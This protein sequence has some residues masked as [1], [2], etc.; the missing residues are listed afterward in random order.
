ML[1]TWP[2]WTFYLRI[3]EVKNPQFHSLYF[4]ISTFLE[5]ECKLEKEKKNSVKCLQSLAVTAGEDSFAEAPAEFADEAAETSHWPTRLRL[6][7]TERP[8]S[9]WKKSSK[10]GGIDLRNSCT[11]L[12]LLSRPPLPLPQ[13]RYLK[14]I[15]KSGYQALPWVRYITQNGGK[16]TTRRMLVH[17]APMRSYWATVGQFSAIWWERALFWCSSMKKGIQC[18]TWGNVARSC[19]M[20]ESWD[21]LSR[22][23][24]FL[25]AL[26]IALP[27]PRT[28]RKRRLHMLIFSR[29]FPVIAQHPPPISFCSIHSRHQLPTHV[30]FSPLIPF[31]SFFFFYFLMW[32][33]CIHF[34]RRLSAPDAVGLS[35]AQAG[36][37]QR[38]RCRAATLSLA[39]GVSHE[40][41]GP[42]V[43]LFKF[44]SFFSFLIVFLT[45]DQCNY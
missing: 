37:N 23:F 26:H 21:S 29:M 18:S 4:L 7:H 45:S 30:H 27:Q 41:R 34:L 33:K 44:S 13:V 17:S 25:L 11:T 39:A 1:H 31:C 20:H 38:G 3:A 36:G 9:P 2:T 43:F 5:T 16:V 12:P 35:R 15:E 22:F 24:F 28:M 19:E 8:L 14:I 42:L 10:T 40:T 32:L 6:S